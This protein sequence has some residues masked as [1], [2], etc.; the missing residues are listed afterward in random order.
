MS[1]PISKVT[2]DL[3]GIKPN[4]GFY[5]KFKNEGSESLGVDGSVTPVVFTLEDL[6]T[7]QK[8][9]IQSISFLMGADEVLDLDNFGD[10]SGPLTNGILFEAG[11]ASAVIK[12]NADVFLISSQQHTSTA[13]SGGNTYTVIS[14]RWDFSDTFSDNGSML[15]DLDS[16]KITIRDNL[17]GITLFRVS[18]HGILLE[19]N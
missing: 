2:V 5:A 10:V 15:F 12:D 7:D 16:F 8:I 6:P 1:Q 19:D 17:S 4:D 11:E 9:L 3:K 18:I 14:G 13:G